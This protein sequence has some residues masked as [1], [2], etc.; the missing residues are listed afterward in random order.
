MKSNIPIPSIERLSILYTILER[1][2]KE[3]KAMVSSSELGKIM[4]VQAHTIRKDISFLGQAGGE[5]G[6]NVL[7]LKNTIK[8]GL[9]FDIPR[10]ACIVGLG[11]LGA[12]VMSFPGFLDSNIKIVA[13]FDSNINL[14]ETFKTDIPLY[15][16]YNIPEIVKEKN[17]EL[18][19][20]TVPA[21]SAQLTAD[22]LIEGNI[23]GIINFAPVIIKSSKLNISIRN[24][25]VLEEFRILSAL[26]S[27]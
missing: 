18:G 16:A 25:H 6:Y 17:I 12:A 20:I 9:G 5:A 4:N 13:G 8:K 3:G 10:K 27:Q 23:K 26:I 15:P 11:R 21:S 14:I 22:R 7:T 2:E 1:C 24:L 19:V